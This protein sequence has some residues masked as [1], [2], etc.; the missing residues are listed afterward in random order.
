M[1]NN[2][3]NPL[4]L[5]SEFGVSGS[6]VVIIAI[7]VLVVRAKKGIDGVRRIGYFCA[8]LGIVGGG[9]L[10]FTPSLATCAGV[11]TFI[12]ATLYTLPSLWG[13]KDKK[14]E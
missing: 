10:G 14:E 13:T 7:W 6:T 1:N 12:L 3:T 4:H 9:V 5:M 2:R 8:A 11:G